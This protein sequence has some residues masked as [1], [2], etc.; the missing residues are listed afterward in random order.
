M[1]FNTSVFQLLIFLISTDTGG[2]F[3]GPLQPEIMTLDGQFSL[4]TTAAN[5]LSDQL[6]D[7]LGMRS[8]VEL[9]LSASELR[10]DPAF[11]FG[12]KQDIGFQEDINHNPRQRHHI[13]LWATNFS[14]LE[15]VLTTEHWQQSAL[16]DQ[17][18]ATIWIGA[19]SENLGL[20]F[21]KFTF[22]IT[23][24]EQGN[25]DL[26]RD[27]LVS[28]LQTIPLIKDISFYDTGGLH[29]GKY[30]LDGKIAIVRLS[31]NQQPYIAVT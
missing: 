23:H 10:C 7:Q 22:Q 14:K 8:R 17:R 30:Q 13:R 31:S 28:A 2:Y 11:L 3:L 12:R 6:I 18:T 16:V 19:A 25:R 15:D 9:L 5:L 4:P 20:G 24:R 21:T 29:V 27:Y 1:G 26:E